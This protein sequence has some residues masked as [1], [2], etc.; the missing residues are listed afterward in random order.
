MSEANSE[1]TGQ[2]K[3]SVVVAAWRVAALWTV[4]E[5]LREQIA[6]RSDV[7]VVVVGEDGSLR[8]R[9]EAAGCRWIAAE[10]GALTPKL[11]AVGI[12]AT[13]GTWVLTTTSQFVPESGWLRSL[14]DLLEDLSAAGCGGSILPPE[15][16]GGVAWASY[17]L[18]YAAV[19][20]ESRVVEDIA[21]DHAV[22][23]GAPLRDWVGRNGD[24]WEPEFHRSLETQGGVLRFSPHFAVRQVG[25]LSLSSFTSQRLRHGFAFGG[26]RS[27]GWSVARRILFFACSPA[28]PAVLMM[29]VVRRWRSR[30]GE[31]EERPPWA[32]CLWPLIWFVGVWSLAEVAGVLRATI[33]RGD[34]TPAGRPSF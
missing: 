3:L 15:E 33:G 30:R 21:A 34:S 13:R 31:V 6:E 27:A 32:R 23:E 8:G 26:Q 28:I 12:A 17:L 1:L 19:G 25:G 22:Y 29:H 9:V 14:E 24:F 4:L 18:R 11:W 2:P 16:R 7:E 10:A 20:G 5:R